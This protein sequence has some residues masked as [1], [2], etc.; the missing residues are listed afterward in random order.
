MEAIRK[1]TIPIGE[2]LTFEGLKA[3]N[4]EA[5]SDQLAVAFGYLPEALQEQAWLALRLRVA[6]D[7]WGNEQ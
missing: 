7:N 6:L 4:P 3:L 5:S 2:S 1:L